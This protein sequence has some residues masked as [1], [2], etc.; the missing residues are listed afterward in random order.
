[1]ATTGSTGHATISVVPGNYTITV[2]TAGFRT[3]SQN[4]DGVVDG[5]TRPVTFQLVAAAA[6]LDVLVRDS[7]GN[8]LA[9]ATVT[10]V[11][12]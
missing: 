9:G 1:M 6:T 4:V 8:P 5:E 2:S 3:A 11:P 7:A 10:A 12:R